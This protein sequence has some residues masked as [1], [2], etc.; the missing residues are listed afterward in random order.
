[1]PCSRAA[2]LARAVATAPVRIADVGG[3]TDT[4]FGSP[5]RVCHLA[6]G[7]GVRVEATLLD[8]DPR[9]CERPVRLVAPDL[10]EDYRVGPSPD[11]GWRAPVPGRHP[12]L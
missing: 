5:G 6:V 8:A 1:M 12:L 3:W 10:A 2:P 4:W 11:A 9:G 7:P